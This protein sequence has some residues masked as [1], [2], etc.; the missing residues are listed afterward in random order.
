MN[1]DEVG[2]L[3]M[4]A[5]PKWILSIGNELAVDRIPHRPLLWI[6]PGVN[7][8]RKHRQSPRIPAFR[9]HQAMRLRP[10]RVPL[11]RDPAL[12][13]GLPSFPSDGKNRPHPLGQYHVNKRQRR[14]RSI[15]QGG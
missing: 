9:I 11:T 6:T 10:M 3:I 14:S 13:L 12:A 4:S 2:R 8:V 7:T 1:L 5:A 15:L